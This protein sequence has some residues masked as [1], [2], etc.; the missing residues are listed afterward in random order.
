[1]TKDNLVFLLG[2]VII[3]IVGGVFLANYSANARGPVPM[4]SQAPMQQ[5]PQGGNAMAQQNLPEGHPP[6]DKEALRKQITEQEEELKKNPSDG[7]LLTSLGN[8]H[9]DLE[10]YDKAVPYY[11]K[12]LAKDPKNVNLLT[13]LGSCYLRQNQAPKALEYYEKSL[14]IEPTHM[15]TLM[16]VGI[17]RMASGNRQGAADAWEKVIQLYP[18]SPEVAMLKDAVKRLREN[19][20]GTM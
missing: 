7:A 11:E 15:Q 16:N 9:F 3:G 8:L 19:P 14:A 4:N 5:S 6:V 1:M 12:A 17:A 13:D 20:K 2:G 10:E 18:N